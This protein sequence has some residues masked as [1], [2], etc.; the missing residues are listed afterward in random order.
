MTA[1]RLPHGTRDRY[2]QLGCRCEPCTAANTREHKLYLLGYRPKLIDGTGTRRRIQALRALGWT[3]A[4]IGEACGRTTRGWAAQ[5]VN[6]PG[7]IRQD[8]AAD[9]A[10]AY[11]RMSAQAPEGK[12]RARGRRL[13]AEQGCYPPLAW[14]D[15]DDPDENPAATVEAPRGPGR[16]E[17]L[18]SVLE[19]FD[20]LMAAGESAE[21][22]ARRLGVQVETVRDYRT[23]QVRR[24]I[25]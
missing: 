8:V 22:T 6:V 7:K 11:E 18:T 23:R 10:A 1:D 14:D 2:N 3:Y 4:E 13:A 5:L 19:D 12:F 20:W 16:P 21:L 9:I 15:I 25:A 24:S 17:T